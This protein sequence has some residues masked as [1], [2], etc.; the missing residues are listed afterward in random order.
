MEWLAGKCLKERDLDVD[1]DRSGGEGCTKILHETRSNSEGKDR[2]S[3][4]FRIDRLQRGVFAGLSGIRSIEPGN[5]IQ[6]NR[7]VPSTT[8]AG[9]EE[10]CARVRALCGGPFTPQTEAELRGLARKLRLAIRQHV[11]MA[12]SSLSVKKAAIAQRDSGSE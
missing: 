12:K 9:I 3:R 2:I 8:D 7:R 11:Q 4:H 1:P 5:L 6:Y 10:L